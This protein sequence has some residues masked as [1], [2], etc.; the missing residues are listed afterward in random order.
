MP[1]VALQLSPPELVTANATSPGWTSWP[2]F[3]SDLHLSGILQPM[4]R[5][6]RNTVGSYNY[7]R[8]DRGE[9]ASALTGE[10]HRGGL[11]DTRQRLHRIRRRRALS[12]RQRQ[13]DN[14]KTER[15]G[16]ELHICC[17]L[18]RS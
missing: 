1:C 9:P 14:P 17:I 16:E 5:S 6:E 12:G 8:A 7:R 18:T 10:N 13:T 15:L 3:K 2:T 11:A 4:V